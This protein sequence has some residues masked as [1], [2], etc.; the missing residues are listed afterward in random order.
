MLS[1]GYLFSSSGRRISFRDSSLA[2]ALRLEEKGRL[3]LFA[4]AVIKERVSASHRAEGRKEMSHGG[5]AVSPSP[6]DVIAS[7]AQNG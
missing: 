2:L 6:R 5:W 7:V 1:F 4:G 3:H